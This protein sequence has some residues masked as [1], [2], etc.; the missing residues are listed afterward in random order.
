MNYFF[1][2]QAQCHIYSHSSCLPWLGAQKCRCIIVWEPKY[3]SWKNFLGDFSSCSSSSS[4]NRPMH[5]SR[6]YCEKPD[7]KLSGY[8][9]CH[10]LFCPLES[11]Q[12]PLESSGTF[13]PW[14]LP[15]KLQPRQLCYSQGKEKQLFIQ[16]FS[17]PPPNDQFPACFSPLER[18]SRSR[19]APVHSSTPLLWGILLTECIQDNAP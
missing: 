11:C 2:L 14:H 3:V 10:L 8:V 6:I 1:L 17:L 16:F 5:F 18:C 9:S 13:L 15:P 4:D 12:S 19:P 7:L